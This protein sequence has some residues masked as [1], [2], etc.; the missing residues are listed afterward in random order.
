MKAPIAFAL[1]VLSAGIGHAQDNSAPLYHVERETFGC[2][3]PVYTRTLTNPQE[4]RRASRSWVRRTMNEGR[5]VTITPRS[6]WKL[7]SLEG[8]VALM[9]YAG[10]SGPPGAYYLN[11][12]QL[13]DGDG[14]HPGDTGSM[15]PAPG[16]ASSPPALTSEP[17]MSSATA[18]APSSEPNPPPQHY[19]DSQPYADL[20]P[21]PPAQSSSDLTEISWILAAT[22]FIVLAAILIWHTRRLNRIEQDRWAGENTRF[23]ISVPAA[24][25]EIERGQYPGGGPGGYPAGGAGGADG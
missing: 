16:A 13:V 20:P 1:L 4:S 19:T 24:H 10:G 3:N 9:S 22:G 12:S 5:C 11:V 21:L 7:V 2:A 6:P 8:D 23:R 17:D 18:L 15:P 14:Q 25:H